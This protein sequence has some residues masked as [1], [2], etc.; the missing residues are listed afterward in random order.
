MSVQI[1]KKVLKNW[2]KDGVKLRRHEAQIF[3]WCVYSVIALSRI[4]YKQKPHYDQMK[5][6]WSLSLQCF[7]CISV[8]CWSGPPPKAE[9]VA[10]RNMRCR[11]NRDE[12]A[13]SQISLPSFKDWLVFKGNKC[14]PTSVTCR[15]IYCSQYCKFYSTAVS[16][17]SQMLIIFKY[18][19]YSFF[20]LALSLLVTIIL[21]SSPPGAA[22]CIKAISPSEG[23][24]TGGATVIIIGDNFFD[25]LQV[26]FGTMLVWSEVSLPTIIIL[27]PC[28]FNPSTVCFCPRTVESNSIWKHTL[29]HGRGS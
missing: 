20:P 6:T 5:R 13:P 7:H 4:I 12:K 24:T 23:W 22:P 10:W 9:G 29:P 16:F 19:F 26:I 3:I 1:Q 17:K 15:V 21:L 18:L 27:S 11:C 8:V 25:G 14:F 2:I 28:C